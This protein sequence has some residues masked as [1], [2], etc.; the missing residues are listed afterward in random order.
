MQGNSAHHSDVQAGSLCMI[1]MSRIPKVKEGD[2]RVAHG[3]LPDFKS[4]LS[5][6]IPS[7]L[8]LP[9]LS[10][11]TTALSDVK[12]MFVGILGPFCALFSL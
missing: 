10:L 7:N 1:T 12:M 4:G 3:A 9:I 5:P 6:F 2:T 8:F 11:R